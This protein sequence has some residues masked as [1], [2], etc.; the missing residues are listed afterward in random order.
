MQ[1]TIPEPL[2]AT[3]E[4]VINFHVTEACNYACG[5]CYAKW[6]RADKT[7]DLIHDAQKTALLLDELRRFFVPDNLSNPLT[8]AFKWRTVRLNIA[9]GEPLLFDREVLRLARQARE[10]DFDVSIITN[11]SRLTLPVMEQLAPLVSMVGIS[12]DSVATAT[13]SAIGR[14]DRRG[15]LLDLAALSQI[16]AAGR[17]INPQLRLK[18]NTVVNALNYDEDL[19]DAID[20]FA[21][22]KWKVL[23]M[24]PSV[25]DDLS[26]STAQFNDFVQ[27]HAAGGL[28]MCVEDNDDMVASYIMID[29]QGRFYQNRPDE[30]GYRYSSPIIE[31]GASTAFGQITLFADRYLGRYLPGSNAE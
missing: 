4:L 27:R 21:P 1:Q 9:G 3:D 22:E 15:T 23:R 30:K 26:V 11:A 12:I 29:P 14:R 25:T 24:L 10:L 13:N 18:L 6:T 5:Y 2:S 7:R 19:T 8:R 20:S 28:P 31:V 17:R 16:I